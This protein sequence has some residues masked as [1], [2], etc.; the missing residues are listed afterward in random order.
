MCDLCTPLQWLHTEREGVSNH[1]PHGCLLKRFR[2][3]SKK[4]S[5][6]RVT[7]LCEGNSPVTGE[8]PAQ[9]AS[10]AENVSIWWRHHEYH[11]ISVK[12]WKNTSISIS[13]LMNSTKCIRKSPNQLNTDTICDLFKCNVNMCFFYYVHFFKS[14]MNCN[15]DILDAPKI[16]IKCIPAQHTMQWYNIITPDN[17]KWCYNYVTCQL[18]ELINTTE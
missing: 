4:T 3:R 18:V 6:L 9:R 7:G 2:R 15:L 17:V 10:N 16:K 5:K 8:F 11:R 14:R 1:Q 12:G 13:M